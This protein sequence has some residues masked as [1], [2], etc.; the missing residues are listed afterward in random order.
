MIAFQK[1]V[2]PV[3]ISTGEIIYY[4]E[5]MTANV[6]LVSGLILERA[7]LSPPQVAQWHQLCLQR[8]GWA[9]SIPWQYC[10]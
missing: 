10:L 6:R 2:E 8:T 5:E 4:P 1:T 3:E 7:G 9:V